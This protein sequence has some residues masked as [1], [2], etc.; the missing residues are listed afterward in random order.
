MRG[1]VFFGDLGGLRISDLLANI[2][3]KNLSLTNKI[4]DLTKVEGTPG[5]IYG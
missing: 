5:Y 4:D 1:I 3:N 2:K